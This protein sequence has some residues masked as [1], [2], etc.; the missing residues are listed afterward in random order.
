MALTT[1]KLI[2]AGTSDADL[3]DGRHK[4]IRRVPPQVPGATSNA[5]HKKR[6]SQSDSNSWSEEEREKITTAKEVMSSQSWLSNS[7][8]AQSH[9]TG[10]TPS[11]SKNVST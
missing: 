10:S 2:K 3:L 8:A 1:S 7:R 11:H 5:L 9:T 6:A 4:K